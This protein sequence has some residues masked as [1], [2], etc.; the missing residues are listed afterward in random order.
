M[1]GRA[2]SSSTTGEIRA[3]FSSTG[4]EYSNGSATISLDPNQWTT[5]PVR[6]SDRDF[7][8]TIR[9][10]FTSA[11]V[12]AANDISTNLPSIQTALQRSTGVDFS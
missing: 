11:N 9:S 6:H 10:A 4:K 3:R 5:S 8:N 1:S 7:R 2:A 12:R